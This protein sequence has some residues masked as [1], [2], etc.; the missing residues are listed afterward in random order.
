MKTLAPPTPTPE[1][2]RIIGSAHVG[3]EIIRGAA[4]SGKTTTALLRLRNR[5]DTFS[6]RNR[7]LENPEPVLEARHRAASAHRRLI[8][9]PVNH[10]DRVLRRMRTMRTQS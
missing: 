7:R 3:V 6:A 2:L 10:R 4:G 5:T 1:Q 8:L 9:P